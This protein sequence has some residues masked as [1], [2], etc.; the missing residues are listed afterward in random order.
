MLPD[1]TNL[2]DLLRLQAAH[3]PE[4]VFARFNGGPITFATLDACAPAA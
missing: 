3:N 2:V 4:G 1:D